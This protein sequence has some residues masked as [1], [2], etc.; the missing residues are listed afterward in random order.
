MSFIVLSNLTNSAISLLV[1]FVDVVL[2]VSQFVLR[3]LSKVCKALLM[4]VG[5]FISAVFVS[6]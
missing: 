4:L 2:S 1:L 5:A 6:A 3:I